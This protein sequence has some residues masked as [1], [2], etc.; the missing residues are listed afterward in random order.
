M[1]R[2]ESVYRMEVT[3]EDA[4]PGLG[5]ARLEVVTIDGTSVFALDAAWQ[6]EVDA[7]G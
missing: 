4:G 3:P 5:R 6:E 2:P 1:E 7:H